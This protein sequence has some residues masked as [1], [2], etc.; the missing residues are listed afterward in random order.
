M[1]EV[2]TAGTDRKNQPNT[3]PKPQGVPCITAKSGTG[4][5]AV[6]IATRS[7]DTR[8]FRVL[9]YEP[10]PTG[11]HFEYLRLMLPAVR[12]LAS[13]VV[14]G[15]SREGATSEEYRIL[16]APSL[17]K[18]PQ[19]KTQ[20]AVTVD[21]GALTETQAFTET[22]KK[23]GLLKQSLF[24]AAQFV[25]CVKRVQP[26][27]VIVPYADGLSQALSL[28]WLT[29]KGKVAND[30]LVNEA[31]TKVVTSEA[32]FMRGAIAY[33]AA[34]AKRRF[35]LRAAWMLMRRA[36]HNH[37]YHLDPLMHSWIAR[38]YP[39]LICHEPGDGGWCLMPDPAPNFEKL[40]KGEAR[41]RLGVAEDGLIVGALGT[42]D[43]RKG[44]DLLIRAFAAAML[45]SESKLLLVGSQSHDIREM[46]KPGGEAD[47]LVRSGKIIS[48]DRFVENEELG[49]AIQAMDLVAASHNGHIG[50]ASV[51]TKAA[52]ASRPT[53]G[54]DTGWIDIM[55]NRFGL[56]TTC[57]VT[58][59]RAFS[60]ALE[61]ALPA[62]HIWRLN[63][64]GRRFVA[65]H[66]E[67]NFRA[68]WSTFSRH[69]L[70]LPPAAERI[71]WSW[72]EEAARARKA[73]DKAV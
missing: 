55:V 14:L 52:A 35:A 5:D 33:P 27:H 23:T 72:V 21:M 57:R 28:R 51:V 54:S 42:L 16:L 20:A 34:S 68:C 37:L 60:A 9:I 39:K 59:I 31:S 58:D 1:L 22:G 15:T 56:G 41:K 4:I 53:L 26:D 73:C 19:M 17:Q 36:P 44:I 13:H 67:Q 64:A 48:I 70:G 29:L 69:R 8:Q 43:K 71:D 6:K 12:A 25:D 30:R 61:A 47:G 7:V 46:L 18:Q 40:S 65:F 66:S 10:N 45:P 62:A 32:L 38:H 24:R 50:S 3:V 49:W 11:H 63:E 2:S